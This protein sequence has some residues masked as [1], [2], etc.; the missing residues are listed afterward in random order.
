V[1]GAKIDYQ[2]NIFTINNPN[3]PMRNEI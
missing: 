1:E 3:K 2:D